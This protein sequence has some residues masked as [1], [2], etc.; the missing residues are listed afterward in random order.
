[1]KLGGGEFPFPPFMFTEELPNACGGPGWSAQDKR[2]SGY[3]AQ[4]SLP[5]SGVNEATFLDLREWGRVS[6]SLCLGTSQ[7]K[8]P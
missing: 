5:H 3:G 1:M 4:T 2:P 7:S 6:R 8:P